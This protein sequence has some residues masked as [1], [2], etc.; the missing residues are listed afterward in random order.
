MR[1]H[2]YLQNFFTRSFIRN[3]LLL[4]AIIFG[5]VI[6]SGFVGVFQATHS[7]SFAQGVHVDGIDISGMTYEQAQLTL[8]AHTQEVL[9]QVHIS[10]VYDGKATEFGAVNLGVSLNQKEILDQAFLYN[11]NN[12]NS[13]EE[14]YKKT[15]ELLKG[16]N[17]ET[18]FVV[19]ESVL[20]EVIYQYA[21]NYY[22]QAVDAT[23]SFNKNTSKFTYTA[24][25]NGVRID[26]EKLLTDVQNML[27]KKDYSILQVT[28]DILHTDITEKMLKKNTVLIGKYATL[29]TNN[30]NRNINIQL[31]CDAVNGLEIKPQETLSLN[32]LVGKR[33]KAKGFMPA[34]A[35]ENGIIVDDMGGGICQLAGTLYNAALL[36]DMKIVERVRHTWPSNYL[37]IGQ[38]A[39]LNWDNKDL[40]IKN[41]SD[42]S[43][44]VHASFK[45]QKVLVE[46]FGQPLADGVTIKIQN[47]IIEEIPPSK[48]EIK[49]T[50][51]LPNGVQQTIRDAKK[52]YV[53]HVYRTYWQNGMLLHKELISQ[54]TYPALNKLIFVGK[55]ANDK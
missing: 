45:N 18:H 44:F 41:I 52:G 20:H 26:A 27:Y 51:E 38:D 48:V 8:T 4:A 12:T 50:S 32:G 1:Q 46:L 47:D 23:V 17:F 3:V 35:I 39:T 7:Q 21:Q 16:R 40:I 30:K 2:S 34:P 25:K 10:L 15:V 42:Y 9:S 22:Q 31:M 43:I 36:A 28:A 13:I 5:I 6:F 49:Y 33:T 14:Q 55:N 29:A 54:D 37:P 53:V 11:K 24:E 19:D